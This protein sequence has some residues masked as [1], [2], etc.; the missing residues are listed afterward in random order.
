MHPVCRS[1]PPRIESGIRHAWKMPLLTLCVR[2]RQVPSLL[3]IEHRPKL[4]SMQSKM[5]NLTE[6][7]AQKKHGQ[8]CCTAMQLRVVTFPFMQL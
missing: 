3:C 4:M 1:A 5:T 6:E 8:H 7:P 2:H